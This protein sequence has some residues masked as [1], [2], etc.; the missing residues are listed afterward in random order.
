[1]SYDCK[2]QNMLITYVRHGLTEL[3]SQGFREYVT[4][5]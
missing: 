5:D 2:E 3:T 1:M 4:K